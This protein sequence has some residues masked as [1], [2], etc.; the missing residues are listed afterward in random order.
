MSTALAADD[1]V[2]SYRSTPV[3]RGVSLDVPTGSVT[4][5]IGPNGAGKT[6]LLSIIG[7]LRRQD[8]G[9]V[10]VW[11]RPR[12]AETL[13]DVGF[14]LDHPGLWPFLTGRGNLLVHAR[15][16]GVP[17]SRVDTVLRQVDMAEHADRKVGKYSLGMR[18]RLGIAI[19][20]VGDPRV[21]VLDEPT[22]GLDPVGIRDMRALLRSLAD[23]G[24]AVLISSH[25]LYEVAQICDRISVL[26]SGT[27][28]YQGPLHGLADDNDLEAAFFRL[29]DGAA[30]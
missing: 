7:G 26:V 29:I 15:L 9:N 5:L 16:R 8:S 1:I 11:G 18:W 13:H 17:E 19:A 6:T 10:S 30:K 24:R 4:G 12:Q 22:N 14:L 20:L 23:E 3:L 25:Q 28:R 21:L 27:M 2:K